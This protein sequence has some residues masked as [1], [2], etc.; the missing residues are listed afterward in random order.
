MG[1][2]S[3]KYKLNSLPNKRKSKWLRLIYLWR[4][5]ELLN[6]EWKRF[7]QVNQYSLL[8]SPRHDLSILKFHHEHYWEGIL[9]ANLFTFQCRTIVSLNERRLKDIKTNVTQSLDTFVYFSKNYW[10]FKFSTHFID[11]HCFEEWFVKQESCSYV[12]YGKGFEEMN[13]K[14]FKYPYRVITIAST[15]DFWLA[16]ALSC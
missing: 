10:I 6:E 13:R 3:N 7:Y 15:F 12:I 14:E 5:R 4:H 9:S 8:Q 11:F 1:Q 2:G 16:D